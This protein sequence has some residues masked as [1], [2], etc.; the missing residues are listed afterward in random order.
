[1]K[2]L[3]TRVDDSFLNP[4]NQAKLQLPTFLCLNETDDGMQK[5]LSYST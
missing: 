2:N 3:R 1:M 5:I 4:E